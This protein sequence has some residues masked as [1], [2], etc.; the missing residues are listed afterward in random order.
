VTAGIVQYGAVSARAGLFLS[1]LCRLL[2]H[3]F[4]PSLPHG[5][6]F[7]NGRMSAM[8]AVRGSA[9]EICAVGVSRTHHACPANTLGRAEETG[10][11]AAFPGS[12]VY[13]TIKNNT[14]KYCDTTQKTKCE[15]SQNAGDPANSCVQLNLSL[16][17]PRYSALTESIMLQLNELAPNSALYSPSGFKVVA[18]FGLYSVS[19]TKNASDVPK[20]VAITHPSGVTVDFTF[21]DGESVGMPQETLDDGGNRRATPRWK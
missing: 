1:R 19:R 14:I 10:K 20:Y 7:V 6:F 2:P 17:R 4:T 16:G 13:T 21:A 8:S 5:C 11:R 12:V 15:C 3:I 18:G 9:P